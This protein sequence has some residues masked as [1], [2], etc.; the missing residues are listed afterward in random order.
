MKTLKFVN[1]NEYQQ[2]AS[3]SRSNSRL[4]QHYNLFL[5]IDHLKHM[6][7]IITSESDFYSDWYNLKMISFI[8]L[9]NDH[10]KEI[11]DNL[12]IDLK[13]KF[14]EVLISSV[15]QVIKFYEDEQAKLKITIGN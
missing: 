15:A 4:R 13:R 12:N 8:L 10:P 11:T 3:K 9:S 1:F 14:D 7:N 5:R 6:V 2:A